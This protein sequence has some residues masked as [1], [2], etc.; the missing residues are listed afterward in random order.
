MTATNFVRVA[1][2]RREESTS[3]KGQPPTIAWPL[4]RSYPRVSSSAT[5]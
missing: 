1:A 3:A 2:A 5:H 4:V